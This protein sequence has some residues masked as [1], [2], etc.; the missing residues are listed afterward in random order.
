VWLPAREKETVTYDEGAFDAAYDLI[1]IAREEME[2]AAK[3][4]KRRALRRLRGLS[5]AQRWR[6]KQKIEEV[7]E[8][9]FHNPDS[10]IAA[11][12]LMHTLNRTRWDKET[13]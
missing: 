12:L 8:S 6:M 4:I 11:R 3:Q 10:R 2:V 7:A 1:D 13:P 5:E 9:Y